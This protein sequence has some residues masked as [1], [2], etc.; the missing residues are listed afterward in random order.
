MKIAILT[1]NYIPLVGGAEVFVIKLAKFLLKK[2]HSVDIITL[3][4]S[5]NHPKFEVIDGVNVYRVNYINFKGLGFITSCLSLLK[6]ILKNN[7]QI[8]YDLIHSV[9]ESSTSQ[10][11]AFFKKIKKIPHLITIQG[12]YIAERDYLRKNNNINFRNKFF[13]KFIRWSFNN[14]DSLH[15]ISKTI[16][17]ESKD[18]GAKNIII[19]PNGVDEEMIKVGLKREIRSKLNISPNTKIIISLSRLTPRKGFKYVIMAFSK[20]VKDFPD[21]RLIIIGD[22]PQR[23][24]LEELVSNLGIIDYVDFKGLIPHVEITKILPAADVFALT[25]IYEGLGIVYIESLACEVP[26]ITTKVGGIP[27]II[28][29]GVNGLFVSH[30][31]VE[32][33]YNAL[34]KLITDKDMYRRFQKEGIHT[35]KKKFIWEDIFSEIEDIYFSL[36]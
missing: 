20:F 26:V 23:Q 25:P 16:A 22:G 14:A 32:E 11:G 8:K 3:K 5:K 24:E 33:L 15:A 7:P 35:V 1:L 19:I 34:N 12:G 17:V 30:G 28:K 13:E 21:S 10:A 6:T 18:L 9:G 29:D 2:G 4:H 36:K 31:D 27:D